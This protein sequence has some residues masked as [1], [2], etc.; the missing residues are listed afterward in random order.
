MALRFRLCIWF[1]A[2]VAASVAFYEKAFGCKLRFMPP[3]GAFAELETGDT[4]LC[5]L[6]ESTIRKASL[7]P[8]LPHARNR[9][10][11]AVPGA[12]IAFFPT[13]SRRIGSARSRPGQ[14]W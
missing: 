11:G 13:T 6:G 10:D 7:F 3:S 5:F 14:R 9:A 12:Q 8:N 4:L 1:V 2:D